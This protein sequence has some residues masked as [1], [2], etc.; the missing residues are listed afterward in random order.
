VREVGDFDTGDFH[1]K[2]DLFISME[3]VKIILEHMQIC[4]KRNQNGKIAA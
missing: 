4:S 2:R 3:L 1:K